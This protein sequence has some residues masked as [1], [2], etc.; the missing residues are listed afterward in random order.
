VKLAGVVSFKLPIAR[1]GHTTGLAKYFLEALT[2]A[3]EGIVGEVLDRSRGLIVARDAGIQTTIVQKRT[4]EVKTRST[5]GD[6]D[7]RKWA[8]SIRE[9][10]VMVKSESELSRLEGAP[11]GGY[12]PAEVLSAIA[13]KTPKE[14]AM[15][16][17]N[18][19]EMGAVHS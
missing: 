16:S 7:E 14:F 19:K 11:R 10:G 3:S 8:P 4:L 1:A 13:S 12:A 18:N 6:V 5:C 17:R 15:A 9:E 2:L